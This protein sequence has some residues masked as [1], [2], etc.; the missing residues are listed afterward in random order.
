MTS[1]IKGKNLEP[2]SSLETN[3]VYSSDLQSRRLNTNVTGDGGLKKEA[4]DSSLKI[5]NSQQD[6]SL[7]IKMDKIPIELDDA[8]DQLQSI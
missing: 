6:R 7:H 2:I 1:Q 5:S 4:V 3:Q 8:F